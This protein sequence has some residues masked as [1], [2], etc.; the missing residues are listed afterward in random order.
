MKKQSFLL[1]AVFGALAGCATGDEELRSFVVNADKSIPRTTEPL[2]VIQ[3]ATAKTYDGFDL[4]DPFSK[5]RF[6]INR[7]G[8]V[9]AEVGK[10]R[11]REPLEGYALDQ[12]RM[13]GMIAQDGQ[14][15]AL[16]RANKIVYRVAAGNYLGQDFGR[17][18]EVTPTSI[19]LR[20]LVQDGTG[21]WE[22][23]SVTL[24][25]EEVSGRT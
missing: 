1:V 15:F 4:A 16:V 10:D 2:P 24:G 14:T 17:I 23:R 21:E 22:E 20:E 5:Q 19:H 6:A 12:L 3:P 9:P 18:T 11:R 25:L 7:N 8:A 13:V